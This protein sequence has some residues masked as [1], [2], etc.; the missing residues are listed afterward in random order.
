MAGIALSNNRQ[1]LFVAVNNKLLIYSN[2][3]SGTTYTS[4][5]TIST[6]GSVTLL[7]ASA[8]ASVLALKTTNSTNNLVVLRVHAAAY[9]TFQAEK[10]G[11]FSNLAID[12]T[13]AVLAIDNGTASFVNVFRKCQPAQYLSVTGAN[14]VCVSNC[15]AG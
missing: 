2:G 9:L 6:L 15:Q 4:L 10:V 12:A 3:G 7:A 14:G 1:R 8:D 5:Q 11:D 13:G